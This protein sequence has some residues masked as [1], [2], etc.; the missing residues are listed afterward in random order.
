LE[1]LP[2]SGEGDGPEDEATNSLDAEAETPEDEG[3][4]DSGGPIS[5]P[6]CF[7]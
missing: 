1:F 2:P 4:E 7:F 3:R 5:K 6:P